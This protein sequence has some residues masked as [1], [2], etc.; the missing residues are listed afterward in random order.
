MGTH[1]TPI[2]P[3][4]ATP[5]DP[6]GGFTLLEVMIS[7]VIFAIGLMGLA[8]ATA[9]TIRTITASELSTDRSLAV[10]SAIEMIRADDF[11]DRTSGTDTVGEFAVRWSSTNLNSN[12]LR[13]TLVS[14]GPGID[15]SGNTVKLGNAVSDTTTFTIIRP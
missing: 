9:Y 10:Q 15:Y 11:G 8:G 1:R 7:I 14:V 5:G 12:T 6:R 13:Y 2:D 4:R 3:G